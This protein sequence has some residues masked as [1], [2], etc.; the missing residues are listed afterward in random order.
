[1][2][3]RSPSLPE[4]SPAQREIM[5]IV[6]DRGEVTASDVREILSQQRDV[7]RTTVRTLLERMEEKGWLKHR[8]GGRTYFYSAAQPR[9]A[10]VAQKV[11]EVVDGVCGGSPEAL[12]NALLDSRG[13]TRSELARIRSMLDEAKAKKSINKGH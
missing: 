10:T 3:S 12:V 8:E 1:M 6:W 7:A 9:G 5:Q 2:S 11:L 13:L 4:L